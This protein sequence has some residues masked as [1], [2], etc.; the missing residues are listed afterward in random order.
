LAL[1]SVTSRGWSLDIIT[2]Y[3]SSDIIAKRLKAY[4]RIGAHNHDIMSIFYGSLL[5][6]AHAERRSLGNGT[7]ISFLQ[8]SNHAKYLL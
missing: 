8:E 5:G 7:C 3:T 2:I 6:D 1:A 4:L